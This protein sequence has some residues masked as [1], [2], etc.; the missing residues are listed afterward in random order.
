MARRLIRRYRGEWAV[1]GDSGHSGH[2]AKT[3][4]RRHG[5]FLSRTMQYRH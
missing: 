4:G 1:D 3:Y 2:R 5:R